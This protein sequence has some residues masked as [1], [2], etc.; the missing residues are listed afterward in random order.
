MR[1]RGRTTKKMAGGFEIRDPASTFAPVSRF[2]FLLF[3]IIMIVRQWTPFFR[4]I[5]IRTKANDPSFFPQ[6]SLFSA[7]KTMGEQVPSNLP[8]YEG[9][10]QG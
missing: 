10:V 4:R 1:E 2:L 7:D 9:R 6:N 8:H 3:L 5:P